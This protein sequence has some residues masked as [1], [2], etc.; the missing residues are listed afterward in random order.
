MAF[1]KT[2]LMPSLTTFSGTI[3]FHYETYLGPLVFEPFAVDLA[4]RTG[5][6]DYSRILELAC[7]TGR[8]TRHLLGR[9]AA[10]GQLEATDLN[11]EMLRLAKENL[12]DNRIVWAFADAQ[13]LPF[14]TAGFELVVCQFGVMFFADKP[15]AFRQVH[16]VL[17]PGGRFLFNTWDSVEHNAVARLTEEV[18]QEVFPGSEAFFFMKGPH[19]FFQPEEITRLL[20]EAGFTHISIEKVK[21]TAH[22]ASVDDVIRGML[23]GTP[24]SLY[25]QEQGQLAKEV[26]QRL[27]NLLQKQ[28]GEKELAL[29]MQALVCEAVKPA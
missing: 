10:N 11:P 6:A 13:E 9:L 20:K 1:S 2:L 16:R 22:A 7:G 15:G 17:Q 28:Y 4:G 25:L 21:K 19:S 3:P 8:L 5:S 24:L 29:P 23:Q 18:L 26:E 12:H 27:R 14:Q